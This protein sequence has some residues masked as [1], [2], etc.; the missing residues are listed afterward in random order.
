[1]KQTRAVMQHYDPM[2]DFWRKGIDFLFKQTPAIV[3]SLMA[4]FVLWNE[5][6]RRDNVN[7]AEMA[8]LNVEWSAALNISN[9]NWRVCEEKREALAIE[10]EKLKVRFERFAKR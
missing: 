4:C 10:V 2:A 7:R 1:M 5:M 9:Q 6:N 8:R 3:L